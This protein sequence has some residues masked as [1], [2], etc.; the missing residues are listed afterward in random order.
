M[1]K[2]KT[3]KKPYEHRNYQYVVGVIAVLALAIGISGI[4][5]NQTQNTQIALVQQELGITT[6]GS[7]EYTRGGDVSIYDGRGS[8]SDG[9]RAVTFPCN[10][11]C[12]IVIEEIMPAHR[13]DGQESWVELYNRSNQAISLDGWTLQYLNEATGSSESS[14]LDGVTMR[15][16]EPLVFC[17]NPQA[18]HAFY[19]KFYDNPIPCVSVNEQAG[20]PNKG[21]ITLR[22][23]DHTLGDTVSYDVTGSTPKWNAVLDMNQIGL[24]SIVLRDADY[25]FDGSLL[26]NRDPHNWKASEIENGPTHGSP[27]YRIIPGDANLE[28]AGNTP[29]EY[30]PTSGDNDDIEYMTN[31]ILFITSIIDPAYSGYVGDY[32]DGINDP[33]F[34]K[35]YQYLM[36][37]NS[38]SVLSNNLAMKNIQV[39]EL[40]VEQTAVD[41]EQTESVV[42][43]V[44]LLNAISHRNGSTVKN[45]TYKLSNADKVATAKC[46]AQYYGGQIAYRSF[47]HCIDEV[48][49]IPPINDIPEN[50][51]YL[52]GID[53]ITNQNSNDLDVHVDSQNRKYLTYISQSTGTNNQRMNAYRYS[54]GSWTPL[55][56]PLGESVGGAQHG[57]STMDSSDNLYTVFVSVLGQGISTHR[58]I[59]GTNSWQLIGGENLIWGTLPRLHTNSNN[60][61]FLTYQAGPSSSCFNDINIMKYNTSSDQWEPVLDCA[62]GATSGNNDSYHATAY[63]SHIDIVF[64]NAATKAITAYTYNMD[65]GAWST[66]GNTVGQGTGPSITHAPDGS[67]Y[68]S[69]ADMSESTKLSVKKI[70]QTGNS[71]NYVGAPGFSDPVLQTVQSPNV[72]FICGTPHIVYRNNWLVSIYSFSSNQWSEV[73]SG[74]SLNPPVDAIMYSDAIVDNTGVPFFA[75]HHLGLNGAP[76][77]LQ[78][79]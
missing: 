15:P 41:T 20:V 65:S 59:S 5:N 37:P 29:Q 53:A 76:S 39:L 12:D 43:N 25:I 77:I 67:H 27:G 40:T 30:T 56:Q 32:G 3:H 34:S 35:Y 68:V 38:S 36:S 8:K 33:N 49:N 23:V 14:S 79:Q 31:H 78:L 18:F 9:D 72:F 55:G 52:G 57:N 42:T 1:S 4:A 22:N 7:P 75:F 71:W 26:D 58:Y 64:A 50:W 24:K 6:L 74:G 61:L 54:S 46:I 28:M 19:S 2:K 16:Y 70:D 73:F 51:S 45:F 69:Y 17:T 44:P 62:T 11:D 63:G 10:L 47:D 60:D 66:T 13:G 48:T 21:K